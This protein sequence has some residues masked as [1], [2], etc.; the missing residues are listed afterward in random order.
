MSSIDVNGIGPYYEERGRGPVA[1][2]ISG[3]TG[4]AGRWAKVADIR[5]GSLP[6]VDGMVSR[7]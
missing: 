7:K 1:L 3:A 6:Y 2:F 5:A 4:D